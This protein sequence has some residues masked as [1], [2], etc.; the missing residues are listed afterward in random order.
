MF[1]RGAYYTGH[2]H[3]PTNL[4]RTDPVFDL[5]PY[6]RTGASGYYPR[7]EMPLTWVPVVVRLTNGAPAIASYDWSNS[8]GFTGGNKGGFHWT[9]N[10]WSLEGSVDGVSWENVKLDGGDFSITTNSCPQL[11]AGAQ[12]V[13]SGKSQAAANFNTKAADNAYF[14]A[15]G[16]EIRGTA[17]NSYVAFT[18]V[19]SVQVDG[20]AT[21][22]VKGDVTYDS[23]AVDA[24]KGCGTIKGGA[25]AADGTV[26]IANWEGNDA[27]TL[28]CGFA[29]AAGAAN[30]SGWSVKVGGVERSRWHVK[31]SDGKLT[32]FP[33][34]MR[35]IF[36]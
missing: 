21:L 4:F 35:M 7:L 20:G 15:D 36:R 28:G 3:N 12:F 5:T 30:I 19:R 23:L 13:F 24:A 29:G 18:N 16:C 33:P 32:V 26:D 6:S 9:P 2:D 8:Y 17:T 22:E 34:G 25:F 11:A 14:H 31:Y 1:T 27:R 10:V